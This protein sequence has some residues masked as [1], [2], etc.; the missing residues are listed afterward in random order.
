MDAQ[1]SQ[2]QEYI[3][4]KVSQ[5]M[6]QIKQVKLEMERSANYRIEV[7][8]GWSFLDFYNSKKKS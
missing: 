6:S 8:W 2:M 1:F 7:F 5:E 4:E 3:R